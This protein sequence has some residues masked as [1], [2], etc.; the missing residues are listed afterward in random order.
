VI[1]R[2]IKPANIM[3]GDFGEVYVLDWGV[4]K[5]S[6]ETDIDP[7]D[8]TSDDL[9]TVAGVA[10]GTPAYM[11][12]EQ[13]RGVADLDGRADVYSLGC[14]LFEILTREQFHSLKGL[15]AGAED[16]TVTE[17]PIEHRRPAKRAPDRDVPPELD[18]LCADAT[19]PDRAHRPATAR[20][21]GRAVQQFL[22]GDRDLAMRKSLAQRHL[23]AAQT[24]FATREV[25]GQ[26]RIAIREA[27]QALALDPTL[28]DAATL[29]SRL[30]IEP[31]ATTPKEVQE[32]LA[33]A[34]R[35]LL[36]NHGRV[37]VLTYS[38]YLAFIPLWF[39]VASME[40][41]VFLV[42]SLVVNFTLMLQVS[43]GRI[44][45]S[46]VLWVGIATL[47]GGLAYTF[48]PLWIAPGLAAVI[49]MILALDPRLTSAPRAIGLGLTIIAGVLLP[50]I[51]E[52]LGMIPGTL[53]ISPT[54]ANFH[55]PGL[56]HMRD[57]VL[58]FYVIALVT[59]A[60]AIGY[61]VVC[62][63]RTARRQLQIQAWQLRQLV[64]E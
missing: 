11:A 30:M 31:P 15:A 34:E 14:V 42:C 21:L 60:V 41:F 35:K 23:A 2:D 6:G 46:V 51:A 19:S 9:V 48:S 8:E 59:T 5:V 58:A 17:V 44:V 64:V 4:A 27:G 22:D 26:R 3:L 1:H 53:T 56:E 50:W 49:A 45:P 40:S 37:S 32:E 57:W 39:V 52:R 20:E 43:R 28:A 18:Q 29:V 25:E 13:A 10:I 12:P 63:S 24:A 54:G 7:V 16:A 33:V 38:L 36:R 62:S 61:G 55:A 47:I